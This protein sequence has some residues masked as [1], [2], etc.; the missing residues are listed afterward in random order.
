[1]RKTG[2]ETIFAHRK[3]G[4]ETNFAVTALR[5]TTPRRRN[6]SLTPFFAT[7]P[8]R[9]NSSLT[10]FL[11]SLTLLFV[12]ALGACTVGPDY[13]RPDVKVPDAWKEAPYKTAEPADTLP[14][15][16]DDVTRMRE[17]LTRDAL[18]QRPAAG[19]LLVV[20]AG[21][22]NLI[23][24]DWT[25]AAVGR[26][27]GLGDVIEMRYR[28]EDVHADSRALPGAV[29]WVAGRFTGAPVVNTCAGQAAP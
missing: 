3:M 11:L 24:A 17:W 18:P 27:C 23:R 7:T 15:S 5:I 25:I 28:A 14:R 19:P 9:R 10:P 6:S 26:A 13:V 12:F 21:R 29:D 8:R 2:S 4:S 20:V 16:N 22:D 1:M